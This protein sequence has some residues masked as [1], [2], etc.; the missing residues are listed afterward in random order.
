MMLVMR[1][2]R[3][4]VCCF[5]AIPG[6]VLDD[7]RCSVLRFPTCCAV[8]CLLCCAVASWLQDEKAVAGQLDEVFDKSSWMVFSESGEGQK[9]GYFR[10]LQDFREAAVAKQLVSMTTRRLVS[11]CV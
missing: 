10:S 4:H 3:H 6:L 8:L 5:M 1:W 11:I 2:S 7:V 9:G